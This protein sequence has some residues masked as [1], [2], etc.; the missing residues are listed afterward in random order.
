[1]ISQETKTIIWI[2]II[3]I[4]VVV[5]G[6][7][8]WNNSANT[9]TPPE[10]I[11]V[12]RAQVVATDSHVQGSIDAKVIV[13]EF[14]DYECPACAA[15]HPVT[16]ALEA[17]YADNPNVAFVFRNYPLPQHR[18]AILS[19]QFAEAAALQGKFWEMH[20][21]LYEG[22]KLWSPMRNAESTFLEYAA[23]LGLNIEQLKVDV[24][25]GE[26]MARINADTSAGE[27][28]GV[29][30]TPTF[31]VNGTKQASWDLNKLSAAI[32]AALLE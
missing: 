11:V 6:F 7:Y 24:K 18:Y 25:S 29:N 31:Y 3:T 1:M 12:D 26:V 21:A 9:T 15:A 23:D 22:Q 28:V 27:V 14:G 19:A 17:K 5:A 20:D 2:S 13:T 30:S 10:Q 4:L 8:F 16:K 32:D